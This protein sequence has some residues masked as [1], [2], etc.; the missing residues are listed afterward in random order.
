L[1]YREAHFVAESLAE[2][3]ALV[4]MDLVEINPRLGYL[5]PA[6]RDE[7]NVTIEVGLELIASA[8]GKKIY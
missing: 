7:R 2:T 4:G 5:D 8:L 6:H 1:S 3:G